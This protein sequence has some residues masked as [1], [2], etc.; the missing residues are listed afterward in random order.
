MAATL[1][2]QPVRVA[3]LM[4]VD[5]GLANG[6]QAA[7]ASDREF[8]S[9]QL[10]PLLRSWRGEDLNDPVARKRLQPIIHVLETNFG[11]TSRNL[12]DMIRERPDLLARAE[13]IAVQTVN[14]HAHRL[15][16]LLEDPA[17]AQRQGL[18][19]FLAIR[20]LRQFYSAYLSDVNRERLER[21]QERLADQLAKPHVGA[22]DG[23]SR[24]Q[25]ETLAEGLV[26][27]ALSPL[28]PVRESWR[29]RLWRRLNQPIGYRAPLEQGELERRA[30]GS[31]LS[32]DLFFGETKLSPDRE[33]SL[34]ASAY[35]YEYEKAARKQPGPRGLIVP[36]FIKDL[37]IP[38][39]VAQAIAAG[40]F[41]LLRVRSLEEAKGLLSAAP[42]RER[43]GVLPAMTMRNA[44]LEPI[45][46]LAPS[47]ALAKLYELNSAGQLPSGEDGPA[48]SEAESRRLV[49]WASQVADRDFPEDEGRRAGRNLLDSIRPNPGKATGELE[50]ALRGGILALLERDD[51]VSVRE[52][53]NWEWLTWHDHSFHRS[54][55]SH[56]DLGW[57]LRALFAAYIHVASWRPALVRRGAAELI[58]ANAQ[59][60]EIPLE[61]NAWHGARVD[62]TLGLSM[63]IA[64]LLDPLL[65]NAPEAVSFEPLLRHYLLADRVL[66]QEREWELRHRKPDHMSYSYSLARILHGWFASS[67]LA[68]AQW[69]PK[70]EVERLITWWCWPGTEVVRVSA[71][72]LSL[73]PDYKGPRPE[74]P[75]EPGERPARRPLREDGALAEGE[76]LAGRYE[77]LSLLS[78]GSMSR[79]YRARDSSSGEIMALKEWDPFLDRRWT[80]E[81]RDQLEDGFKREQGMLERLPHDNLPKVG[82]LFENQGRWYFPEE[83]IA[84]ETLEARLNRVGRL[85]VKEALEIARPLL[86]VLGYLHG[87]GLVYRDLKPSNVMLSQAG[88]LV[89]IDLGIARQYQW[90]KI[91]NDT[92]LLGTPGFAAPEQYGHLDQ[93]TDSRADIFAL[94]AL[95]RFMITG[96]DPSDHPFVF[97]PLQGL[98]GMEADALEALDAVLQRAHNNDRE[99]R[100]ANTGEMRSALEKA[101]GRPAGAR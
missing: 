88:R 85:S 48:P 98:E 84:G 23:V 66:E 74:P 92:I 33:Y 5:V 87:H 60:L 14:A 69:T 53:E 80:D 76:R 58:A 6:V 47:G 16:G 99:R 73:L 34:F 61:V 86:E 28:A 79:V 18:K 65:A 52:G 67:L 9:G 22:G 70:D 39:D 83:F 27:E 81:D 54:A 97:Q 89:L 68:P 10:G 30:L 26:Q 100:F 75:P 45:F 51:G 62:K 49:A 38:R 11:V 12:K 43:F 55:S 21:A 44:R 20:Q 77:I 59:R 57:R 64:M 35:L 42:D 3:Q 40:E 1:A 72:L 63:R 7:L 95:I 96:D 31:A 41:T 78:N 15:A 13:E 93:Q 19:T 29:S 46:A 36:A 101:L 8:E 91:G 71:D 2:G 56:Y 4:P 17:L 50:A 82:A 90:D 37:R 24:Q 94:G 25:L 32:H